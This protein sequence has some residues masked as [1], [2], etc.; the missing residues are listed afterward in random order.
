MPASS[1]SLTAV[2][3]DDSDPELGEL[4]AIPAAPPGLW[5]CLQKVTDPRKRRGV[6]RPITGVL[7]CSA[8][9]RR[10]HP[11]RGR[12]PGRRT[13]R[14]ASCMRTSSS[15]HRPA[16]PGSH[17]VTTC[18]GPAGG[19]DR[20]G[21]AQGRT[22]TA[23]WATECARAWRSRRPTGRRPARA[24]RAHH[25]WATTTRHAACAAHPVDDARG[26]VCLAWHDLVWK[27]L[28]SPTRGA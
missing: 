15:S 21:T 16:L 3:V 22:T 27:C 19:S 20:P 24:P 26:A 14:R 6:R 9:R 10:Q 23:P 4:A 11:R 1:S 12:H 5:E 13:Q 25:D 28:T 7:A 17:A 8:R 18:N 2:L